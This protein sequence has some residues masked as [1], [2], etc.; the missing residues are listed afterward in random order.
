M[1]AAKQMVVAAAS[2]TAASSTNPSLI[3]TPVECL[4]CA[5]NSLSVLRLRK[6]NI[7]C[8]ACCCILGVGTVSISSYFVYKLW[9][10]NKKL[11]NLEADIKTLAAHFNLLEE[12]P[13][14]DEDDE[15][16]EEA[17]YEDASGSDNG[18]SGKMIM[19]NLSKRSSSSLSIISS[20]ASDIIVGHASRAMNR[21]KASSA[22]RKQFKQEASTASTTTITATAQ[23][24]NNNSNSNIASSPRSYAS[25]SDLLSYRTPATSPDRF[26]ISS[27]QGRWPS[28]KANFDAGSDGVLASQ[29]LDNTDKYVL[30]SYENVKA[31]CELCEIEFNK[32]VFIFRILEIQIII[33]IEF[34]VEFLSH[35]K[36]FNFDYALKK[37]IVKRILFICTRNSVIPKTKHIFRRANGKFK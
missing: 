17:E 32:V 18:G 13:L 5:A 33:S 23:Q 28:A 8:I 7:I 30:A 19:K 29:Q 24:N 2:S 6:L 26:S 11:A 14:V 1:S 35:L 21:L 31:L 9:R 16:E 37:N 15:D 4:T 34:K 25:E 10:L 22:I 36:L 27:M 12:E 3:I 20:T